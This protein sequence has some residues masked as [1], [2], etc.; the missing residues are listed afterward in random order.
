MER[1]RGR[2]RERQAG[3]VCARTR[4]GERGE[5]DK[6]HVC[7]CVCACVCVCV[8][9]CACVCL[10]VCMR[11]C[12]CVCV[13]VCVRT[14]APLRLPVL[15]PVLLLSVVCVQYVCTKATHMHAHYQSHACA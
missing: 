2:E 7:V 12:T 10:R 4:E 3:K 13:C 14:R 6:L 5:R 9:V 1:K 8:C 11:A 15:V